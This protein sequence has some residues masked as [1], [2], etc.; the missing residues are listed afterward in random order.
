MTKKK[1]IALAA[2]WPMKDER[3]VIGQ[4]GTSHFWHDGQIDDV[5]VYDTGLSASQIATLMQGDPQAVNDNGTNNLVAHYC[6][7]SVDVSDCS[8]NG[9]NGE[10]RGASVSVRGGASL[11]A[12]TNPPIGKVNENYGG[13]CFPSSDTGFTFSVRRNAPVDSF[14]GRVLASDPEDELL[15]YAITNGTASDWLRINEET[16][17]IFVDAAVSAP[18]DIKSSGSRRHRGECERSGK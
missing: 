12:A 16:G 6:F 3:F 14:I 10:L 15:T 17:K 2:P 13:S 9:W 7:D 5:V 8:G 11:S 18:S 1:A 4:Q